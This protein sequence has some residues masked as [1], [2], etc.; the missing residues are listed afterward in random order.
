MLAADADGFPGVVVAAA[1]NLEGSL[2]GIVLQQREAGIKKEV[3]AV[4]LDAEH[5]GKDVVP[6]LVDSHQYD[7]SHDQLQGLDEKCFHLQS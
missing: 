5:P 7:E 3:E 2:H 4:D 1:E 6:E